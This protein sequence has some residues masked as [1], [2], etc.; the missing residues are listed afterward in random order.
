MTSKK[1]EGVNA[2]IKRKYTTLVTADMVLDIYSASQK[3]TN[4][5]IKTEIYNKAIFL[6]QHLNCCI[7][8]SKSQYSV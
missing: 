4:K 2:V 6:S 7:P 5:K 1:E 8:L 3:E